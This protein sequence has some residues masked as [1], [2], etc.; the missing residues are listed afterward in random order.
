MESLTTPF[1]S[2]DDYIQALLENEDNI[3]SLTF[4]AGI[5]ITEI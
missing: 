5:D 4:I 3:K 1:N 2:Y